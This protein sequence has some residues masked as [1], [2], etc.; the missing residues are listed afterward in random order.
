[1]IAILLTKY[2]AKDRL[3]VGKYYLNSNS[4]VSGNLKK[5]LL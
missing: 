4:G 5:N 3:I 2:L 1:M